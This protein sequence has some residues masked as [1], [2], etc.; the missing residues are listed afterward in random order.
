MS[1]KNKN[2]IISIVAILA[3]GGAF[4]CGIKY[5][6][7]RRSNIEKIIEISGKE[8][9]K[10]N[11]V[12]FSDFWKVW[13]LINEKF[14]SKSTTTV[15]NQEKVWGA[16]SGLTDSLGDPFT[17][18]MPPEENKMFET[19][20]SGTFEGVG[21]EIANKDGNLV[22]VSPLKDT[23]AYR[24]GIEP[25]DKILKI[26]DTPATSLKSDQG[27]K[28]IRGPKGT[29]VKLLIERDGIKSPFEKKVIRDTIKIPTIDTE[30]K[31]PGANSNATSSESFGNLNDQGIFVIKL[32]NFSEI[33]PM[34]FRNALRQFIQTG[35]N[36][37]I[38]DLRG[39]P[40]GY[41]QAAIDMASWF[42][43]TGKVIVKEDYG[44]KKPED[45]HRSIGYN[46]FN[47][48]LKMA[49]LVNAGSAS[50]SEILAGALQEHGIAKLVGTKTFGK[51]SVQE[52]IRM[53]NDTSLKLKK[54]EEMSQKC[55]FQWISWTI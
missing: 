25:G 21:M 55:F 31:S 10:P 30:F 47:K 11:S 49:I 19:E 43:P 39:N 28:L 41:L 17:I 36:K 45:T 16:I 4:W 29:V 14:V 7:S 46:V 12:D 9:D 3:L 52:L 2:I 37:L 33:S 13:N 53:N 5:S 8:N 23:P 35:S 15:S 22:V 26:N 42:L 50:A 44:G 40:G 20:I 38:L 51:G 48:N 27:V 24:A 18:F 32:Y 1:S 34:L 54:I 6:E